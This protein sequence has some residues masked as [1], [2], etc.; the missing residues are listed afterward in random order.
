MTPAGWR[1]RTSNPSVDE[2][3]KIALDLKAGT[4]SLGNY[5]G[6]LSPQDKNASSDS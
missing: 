3:H 6:R 2:V 5:N 1:I 4:E